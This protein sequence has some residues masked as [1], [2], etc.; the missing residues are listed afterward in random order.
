M[1]TS[2]DLSPE[3][4]PW[5]RVPSFGEV[6]LSVPYTDLKLDFYLMATDM[7]MICVQIYSKGQQKQSACSILHWSTYIR[8]MVIPLLRRR[9]D[10]FAASTI[11]PC[12]ILIHTLAVHFFLAQR[13]CSSIEDRNINMK[14]CYIIDFFFFWKLGEYL[15]VCTFSYTW[16][17]MITK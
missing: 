10:H 6:V 15:N 3:S 4:T 14:I 13:S 8:P 17:W 12:A 16:C 1:L 2:L 11:W 7:I 5:N 9:V